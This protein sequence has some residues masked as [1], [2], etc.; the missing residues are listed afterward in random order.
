MALGSR[1]SAISYQL[2]ATSYQRRKLRAESFSFSLVAV[3]TVVLWSGPLAAQSQPPAPGTNKP[4]ATP[5]PTDYVIGVEDVLTV[6]FLREKDLTAEVVVR[7]DGKISLPMLNDIQ[8][9]GLTPEQLSA[10]VIEAATK[11]IRDPGVTVMVKEIRSRKVYVVG[12]VGSPGAFP[13]GAEM[14]VL[15]ALAQAGGLLE[16]ANKGDIV[17]VR[18]VKGEEQRFKFNYN[19]VVRGRN[20][21]QNIKLLPGDTILVR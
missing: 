7:P 12:E 16:H 18:T 15:Q 13:L 3:L 11:F 14:N 9:A 2:S 4:A 21:Q 10:T 19:D 17:V 1:L 20:T 6:M 5:L 8:A